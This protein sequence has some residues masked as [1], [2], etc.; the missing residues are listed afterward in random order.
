M[1]GFINNTWFVSLASI[2]IGAMV[3]PSLYRTIDWARSRNGP[4]TGIYLAYTDD[5]GDQTS[6]FLEV[7]HCRHVGNN[8]TGTIAGGIRDAPEG[9]EVPN[10]KAKP[11]YSFTGRKL[12][13]HVLL[14]YWD[15]EKGSQSAGTMTMKIDVTGRVFDG[16][17]SG[18]NASDGLSSR[19]CLWVKCDGD[20]VKGK[21]KATEAWLEG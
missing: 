6:P 17:W 15:T 12:E 3:T 14:T 11:K 4:L 1:S 16:W 13:R 10:F 18:A 20:L 7:V 2:F 8:L 9:D 5:K 21:R 19:R